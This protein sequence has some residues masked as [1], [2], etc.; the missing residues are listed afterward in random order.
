MRKE[1]KRDGEDERGEGEEGEEE[2]EEDQLIGRMNLGGGEGE[3]ESDGRRRGG[4]DFV[5][6]RE[7]RSAD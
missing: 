4:G 1:G 2:E 7:S 6:L 3:D 5:I